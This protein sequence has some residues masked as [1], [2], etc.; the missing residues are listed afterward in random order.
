MKL[1]WT[2]ETTCE[3]K[4]LILQKIFLLKKNIIY[5]KETNSALGT[6]KKKDIWFVKHF[7]P[8]FFNFYSQ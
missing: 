1:N 3:I 2:I 7:T 8:K 4:T 5:Y 6:T